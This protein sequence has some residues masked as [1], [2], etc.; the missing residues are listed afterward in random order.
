M[1]PELIKPLP[2]KKIEIP[3]WFIERPE[4]I[5][6]WENRLRLIFFD[7]SQVYARAEGLIDPFKRT[8]GKLE[9]KILFPLRS[10]GICRCGCERQTKEKHLWYSQACQNFAYRVYGI[11]S[12]GTA[13]IKHLIQLYYGKKC[14]NCDNDWCDIDHIIPVKHGGG[15]CWLSNFMPL[16]KSCHKIKTK[17]DFNWAELYI[18]FSVLKGI[19]AN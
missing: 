8:Q 3:A 10:D 6:Y 17:K 19:G 14:T 13:E 5:E 12:Y 16:C 11:I 4:R 1:N 9:S 7:P 2:F 15:G 18:F